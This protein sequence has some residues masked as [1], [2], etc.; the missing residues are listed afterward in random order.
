MLKKSLI[1]HPKY[2]NIEITRNPRAR[3]IIL[4]ARPNL[5]CITLPTLATKKDLE[6]AL[7]LY[8]DKLLAQQQGMEQKTIDGT[9]RIDTPNFI[10]GLQP[11][12]GE[13]FIIKYN[14]R[15]N[16]LLYPDDT[17]F[18]SERRQAWLREVIKEYLRRRAKSI[19]PGRLQQLATQ[20]GFT[21]SSVSLRDCHT[22][23]GSCSSRGSIS[24]SIYLVLL[25]DEL[26]DYVLL[27]EL[28]HTVEMNHSERFW[29]LLD[30][31]CQCDSRTLR[32][33]LKKHKC[34]IL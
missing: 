26:I 1:A 24:L 14:G 19:L 27:H 21:F 6:K 11:H 32:Q 16:T 20:H 23:W 17:H 5:L 12:N 13:D 30:K 15:H 10:F 29:A 4:R 9:Y 33:A 28:C 7:E 3:R 34:D 22:R 2:G 8:G 18:G 25:P 31:A